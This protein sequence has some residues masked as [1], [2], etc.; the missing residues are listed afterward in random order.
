MS[1]WDKSAGSV[2]IAPSQVVVG[3]YVWLDLS[4]TEHPF[5][6]NRFL[7]KTQK[8]VEIIRSLFRWLTDY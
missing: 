4:W 8:D 2:P 1:L 7:V 5:V 6:T 3:L